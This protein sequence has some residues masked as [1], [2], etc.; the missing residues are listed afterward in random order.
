MGSSGEV[1]LPTR[2]NYSK[3]LG[4]VRNVGYIDWGVLQE[5]KEKGGYHSVPVRSVIDKKL[6]AWL[7][8]GRLLASGSNAAPL[9][10]IVQSP[11]LFPF[12]VGPLSI[13]DLE[14]HNRLEWFRQ[15]LDEEMVMLHSRGTF[16]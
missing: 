5:T 3:S 16:R 10:A 4:G 13:G 8:E 12:I 1:I 6:A 7:I 11:T 14:G 9:K 2:R 15:G